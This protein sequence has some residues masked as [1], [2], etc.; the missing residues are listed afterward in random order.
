ME[1]RIAG[2]S[3]ESRSIDQSSQKSINWYLTPDPRGGITDAAGLVLHPTPG[4]TVFSTVDSGASQVRALHEHKNVLYCVVDD[5][6]YSV[7]SAGTATEE[8][9]LSASSTTTSTCQIASINDELVIVDSDKGYHFKV[10]TST[11]AQIT[12]ADFPNGA[13]TVTSQDGYFMIE[14]DGTNQYHIS[15]LNDGTS[16]N[17]LDFQ[18]AT[19]DS[20]NVVAVKSTGQYIYIIGEKTTEVLYNSGNVDFTFE[21]VGQT[22]INFGCSARHSVAVG[23][24]TIYW[25]TNNDRGNAILMSVN[26]LTVNPITTEAIS[27]TIRAMTTTSDAIGYTY[28]EDGHEFYVVTFPTEDKTLVY[29]I[30][31][32]EWHERQSYNTSSGQY[33]RHI[34]NNYAFFNGEH[35]VGGYNDGK[36]YKMRND[37]YADNGETIRRIRRLAPLQQEGKTITL[38]DFEVRTERGV[39]LETGQGNDPQLSMRVSKDGGHTFGP[40]TDRSPGKIGEYRNRTIWHRLGAGRSMVVEIKA[41]DPVEW[42]IT[43]ASATIGVGN[44]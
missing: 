39:G 25:L 37:I 42:V 23:G 21:S 33:G 20:D 18:S 11:F 4:T 41:T 38:Y 17:A 10:S 12:D 28:Q 43:G 44:E 31:T 36:L 34:G 16:W 26:G 13:Q 1:L 14:K 29:D 3:D 2:P 35:M 19:R 15:A 22:F 40:E 24:S 27:N 8:G 5:K 6:F 30:S 7:D 32:G 9:T